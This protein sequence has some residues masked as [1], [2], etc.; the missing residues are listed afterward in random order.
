MVWSY[1]IA[2][3]RVKEKHQHKFNDVEFKIP[4]AVVMKI[5]IP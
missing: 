5:S 1:F 3:L 2:L 4:T